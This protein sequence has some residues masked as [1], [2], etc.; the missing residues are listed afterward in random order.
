MSAAHAVGCGVRETQELWR[1]A[2]GACCA[3]VYYARVRVT[4]PPNMYIR[5]YIHTEQTPE[6]QNF[7]SGSQLMIIN[8]KSIK[9]PSSN[10]D[11]HAK[12]TLHKYL[13][14]SHK[15]PC[16]AHVG[17][18]PS[19]PYFTINQSIEILEETYTSTREASYIYIYIYIHIYI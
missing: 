18:T 7:Q 16:P 12:D 10:T 14:H 19:L 5:T 3:R 1:G 8:Q 9:T 17:A 15:R 6:P 2:A 13:G 11:A 4:V